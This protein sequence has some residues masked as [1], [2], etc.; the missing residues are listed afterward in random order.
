MSRSART[1]SRILRPRAMAI[2]ASLTLMLSALAIFTSSAAAA[3]APWWHVDAIAFPTNLPPE[4]EGSPA[5][6]G[7]L[8]VIATNLGDAPVKAGE[9]STVS[10][11]LPP[12]LK[13]TAI[14]GETTRKYAPALG[15]KVEE[16][17]MLGDC[18]KPKGLTE[19]ER[20]KEEE[21]KLAK[22]NE[23]VAKAEPISC[24][25]SHDS[26][27]P[28]EGLIVKI[29]V[30]VLEPKGTVT[31]LA[32]SAS[33]TGAGATMS[34]AR[35]FT[36]NGAPT[37]FGVH[38]F[39]LAP[40]EEGGAPAS[41]AGSH[42]FQL[43]SNLDF[44]LTRELWPN[45]HG[46]LPS[47]PALARDLAFHLPPGVLGNPAATPKC[48]EAAFSAIRQFTNLCPA[49]TVIGAAVV[50]VNEPKN[51]N[52]L[53]LSVPV[54]N[55]VPARG[56]PARFGFFAAHTVV[57][58]ETSVRSSEE[59][60]ATATVR[61]AT[62]TAEV[63]STIVTLWGSPGN[64]VHQDARGWQC[65][66]GEEHVRKHEVDG[67]NCETFAQ[68]KE[69]QPT[70][71]F[72]I[73]PTNCTG[74][75]LSTTLEGESWPTK[76]APN[77][78]QIAPMTSEKPLVQELTGCGA[79][80]FAP[81][82]GVEPDVHEASTPSGLTTNV[83][84]PQT[85]TVTEGGLA[86]SAVRST[87]VTLPEGVLLNPGA[88]SGLG[89]CSGGQIGVQGPTFEP[90]PVITENKGFNEG[91]PTC[92]DAAKVGTVQIKTPVL[93]HEIGTVPGCEPTVCGEGSVYLGEQDTNPFEPPL[94][95]YIVV[96]DKADGLLVKLAGSVEPN[97]NPEAGPIGQLKS[98]FKETPKLPFES[99]KLHFFGEGRA[100]T[101][102]PAFCGTY[103]TKATFTPWSGA[104]AVP[105]ETYEAGSG[106]PGFEDFS[107]TSGPGGSPC[108]PQGQPLPFAP[109]LEAGPTKGPSGNAEQLNAGHY[110]EFSTTIK[111]PDGS[112]PLKGLSLTLPPG[113][114]AKIASVEPCPDANAKADNCPASSEVG[115][116]TAV[117]GLGNQPVTLK[118][119]LYLTAGYNGAPFGLLA[120]TH[121]V[122]GPFNLGYI[123]V[124]STLTVNETTA[125]ATINTTDPIPEFI[126]GA[127]AQL[128][129]LN[130]VVNRKEFTFNPTNCSPLPITGTFSAYPEGT[131][132]A[133]AMMQVTNCP[134]LSFNP[135]FEA[136]AE[137]HGS[138][139][140]GIGFKVI[141]TSQGIGV[142]NIKRVHV[143]LPIQLPSRLPTL[144]KAC[145]LKVFEANPAG[146][147]EG[148]NIGFAHI[149]TPVLKNPLAGPA[150]LV[151]HGNE[152]FP[153]VE[154]VLQGEG[155]KLLLDGKTDI[156]SPS[157]G[158]C[159]GPI[160]CITY[161]TFESTPDAPFTRF[162]TT[163]P[164]GP[165]SIVTANVPESKH[166][167]LCGE[168][169]VMPTEITSQSGVL[170]KQT[171]HVK[172]TGCAASKPKPVES[173]LA[174]AL[175]SCRKKYKHNKRKR[176]SCE[177]AAKRKYGKKASHK[178]A[179]R[180]VR[181]R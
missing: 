23:K 174:K 29:T 3:P 74:A 17:E 79:L 22:L 97:Q 55:L 32:N 68:R 77:G 70:T 67:A 92:P 95:L 49:N 51:L 96:N 165:H 14:K 178:A 89:V 45:G 48:S 62:E 121:A 120:V 94:V 39:E 102:N 12:Q 124:R 117:A 93:E 128:K 145:L 149:E 35:P 109:S 161:S 125:Q 90:E 6:V 81:A 58:I 20:K 151:S 19:V 91:T 10:D 54:F 179:H 168:S 133:N 135:G 21:E 7:E 152:A 8:E 25:Y 138:K 44:N 4:G 112:R 158:T 59:Y 11:T 27:A 15:E 143:A 171:T 173:K 60:A 16:R 127:P 53:T 126:K 122:V 46:F 162:E 83:A 177:R 176:S 18:V 5:D 159:G 108:V 2:V 114:A 64:E 34:D 136:E 84:V 141:T 28:Y 169:L 175:K 134:S 105:F 24:T 163:F 119:K 99:L 101:S 123:P 40:E 52:D 87:T 33:V 170:I 131:A 144:Q 98:T 75:P 137:G 41:S 116:T 110:T 130:V 164:A 43:T 76:A 115:E 57:F 146:C 180:A 56:E 172:L 100:S 139:L 71:P 160:P 106:H 153:D 167:E 38:R 113:A 140:S 37:Q 31:S 85:G 47:S 50:H 69:F 155:I 82:L 61:D 157:G 142:A 9:T 26:I 78:I 13:I 104:A 103:R 1:G 88:A 147:P 166:F 132:P 111:V 148:A 129:E 65:I 42:P 72:L 118:G 73:M 154:F 36:V 86:T 66:E 30:Q 150:Y 80:P 156:K 107:I 63:L 181:H